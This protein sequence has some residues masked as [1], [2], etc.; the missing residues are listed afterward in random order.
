MD[1]I[2]ITVFTPTFNRAHILKRCYNSLCNQSYK[3]F[4]W[5]VVDDGSFDETKEL[6]EKWTKDEVIRIKYIYQENAGK[7]MAVNKA[8]LNCDTKYFAFLDSDDFYKSTTIEKMMNIFKEIEDDNLIAGI[9]ARRGDSENKVVG[10]TNLPNSII[11][12][13]YWYLI[14]KFNYY[15]DTCRAYR[16]EVLRE[17]LY[18][19]TGEK[20]IPENVMFDKIDKKYKLYIINEIFSISEYKQDGYTIKNKKILK[21]N[22]KGYYLSLS[23]QMTSKYSIKTI[24]KSVISYTIWCWKNG[25]DKYYSNCPRKGIYILMLPISIIFYLLK[26]PRWY[27]N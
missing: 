23:E 18:P 15:G 11:I 19:Y 24:I 12:E 14:N 13:H 10:S 1:K 16:T 25:I 26:I 17:F 22:P 20:F 6:I 5:L 2:E 8:V 4:I 9:M 7:Q 21:E 3:K 27:F